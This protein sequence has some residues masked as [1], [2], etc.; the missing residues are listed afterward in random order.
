[1]EKGREEINVYT[2]AQKAQIMRIGNLYSKQ[3]SEQSLIKELWKI[4]T[5][6]WRSYRI[7]DGVLVKAPNDNGL[8]FTLRFD[9]VKGQ[10]NTYTLFEFFAENPR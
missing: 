4:F 2:K 5:A 3:F 9:Y 1:M 6:T 8:S 10:K 7:P